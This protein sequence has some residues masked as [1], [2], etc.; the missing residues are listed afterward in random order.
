MTACPEFPLTSATQ[1]ASYAMRHEL[2]MVCA[3]ADTNA[4]VVR[5]C[6]VWT[7]ASPAYLDRATASEVRVTAAG[8]GAPA[9]TLAA[10]VAD[11]DTRT[12]LNDSP[13]TTAED[14]T[15]ARIIGR[16]DAHANAAS[17]VP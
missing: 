17:R 12:A 14:T 16:P 7:D 13:S 3:R 15:R 4:S 5:V 9:A 2:V 10:G 8:L 1:S 11:G 6:S